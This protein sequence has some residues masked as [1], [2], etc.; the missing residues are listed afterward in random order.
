M[1]AQE[2]ST[3]AHKLEESGMTQP[4]AEAIASA[5]VGAFFFLFR[6]IG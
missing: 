5:I 4:R 1:Q 6:F 3:A 2:I